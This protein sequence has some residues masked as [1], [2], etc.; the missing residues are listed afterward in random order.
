MAVKQKTKRVY[1][2]GHHKERHTKGFIKVYAPYLP[3]LLIVGFGIFLSGN[4]EFRQLRSAVLAY[5]TNMSDD[6]LLEATNTERLKAGLSQLSYDSTLDAAAQAKAEDMADRNYWSHNTP[7]GKEPWAFIDQTGYR[8]YKAAENLAYG[9]A[10]SGGAVNG[11]MNSPGH[12][13]NILDPQ[14]REVGFGIANIPNYQGNGPETLVV[15]MY[16]L[17]AEVA[18]VQDLKN[19]EASP[20]LPE[21]TTSISYAEATTGVLAPWMTFVIG[22]IAGLGAMYITLKHVHGLH[23]AVK[24]GER[25]VLRHPLFD[26]TV[27]ALI[28]LATL[29]LQTAGVIH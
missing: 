28:A 17:P 12:R 6:G 14:L 8:Y 11:W 15:A 20:K 9:F 4:G 24:R 5:A 25:F 29:L 16:G 23:R 18:A 22:L 27:I 13:A 2:K 10:T 19:S 21:S 26:I 1:H 3:L 7:D